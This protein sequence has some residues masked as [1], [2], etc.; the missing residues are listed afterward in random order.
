MPRRRR[1]PG[2]ELI[3]YLGLISEFCE[4]LTKKAALKKGFTETRLTALRLSCEGEGIPL[5]DLRIFLKMPRD[6]VSKLVRWLAENRLAEIGVRSNDRR[7]KILRGTTT[8][9]NYIRKIDEALKQLLLSEIPGPYGRVGRIGR[10]YKA[11]ESLYK[12]LR[13]DT[14]L[15]G[16]RLLGP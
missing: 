15:D 16:D 14:L 10:A 6:R 3:R 12:E 1:Y 13:Q 4:S 8:G 11:A 9:R 7:I 2:D 5:S